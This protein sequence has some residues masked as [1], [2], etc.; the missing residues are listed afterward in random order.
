[1]NPKFWHDPM[2]VAAS[3]AHLARPR[4]PMDEM[5][6]IEGICALPV[7][8]GNDDISVSESAL[9]PLT[10]EQINEGNE[11]EARR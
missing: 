8:H 10:A 9:Y 7:Q 4:D 3:L 1:M 5:E 6:S 11:C 2:T